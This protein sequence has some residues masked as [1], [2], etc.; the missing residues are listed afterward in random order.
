MSNILTY[1]KLPIY[2]REWC[3]HHFGVPCEF[4]AA[5]N[6]NNVIRHFS[7]IRPSDVPPETQQEGELAICIMGSQSKKPATYNYISKA[8]KDAIASAIDNIFVMHMWEELTDIGCRS[9]PL[10]KLIMDWMESN[11]ISRQGNNYE[12][13]RMKFQRIK[14]S[15]NKGA[16]VNISR[17]YKHK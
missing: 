17:G 1:V 5:S 13:L 12:N 9:V 6:I 16:G 10:S 2:E 4:P 15:Y 3:E 11:G 8:G 14:D 7:R